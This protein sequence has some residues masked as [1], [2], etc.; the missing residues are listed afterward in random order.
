MKKTGIFYGST[1]GNTEAVAKT[2]AKKLN[3]ECFDVASTPVENILQYDHLILGT[4][5]LGLGDLQDDW[6]ACLSNLKG[7][8]LSGKTVALFGLGD[9]GSYPDTFVDGLGSLYNVIKDKGCILVG[10]VD[11]EEYE[12][13]DST[14]LVDGKFVGLPLDEDN[15]S[16]LTAGRIEKWIEKISPA[17]V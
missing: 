2:I 10:D 11:P 8:D 5:T 7:L 4:S 13:D 16:G 17:F 6:E 12:F 1:T 9:A 14:A 3:A 15:E